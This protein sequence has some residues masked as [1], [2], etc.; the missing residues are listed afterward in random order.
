MVRFL[1][2]RFKTL[3]TKLLWGRRQTEINLV[4]RD[5][6]LKLYSFRLVLFKRIIINFEYNYQKY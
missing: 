1:M 5:F 6:V 3:R 2:G 4:K